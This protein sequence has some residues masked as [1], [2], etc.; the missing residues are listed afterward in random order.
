MI[1]STEKCGRLAKPPWLKVRFPSGEESRRLENLLCANNL[2]SVCVEAHC[3]NRG[4]C[5]ERGTATFLIMGDICT[6]N[7]RFCAVRTGSPL[8]LDENEPHRLV[9][10]A[11]SMGLRHVVITSVTRDD[12]EDGG[13][14]FYS[15]VIRLLHESNSQFTIEVLVPDFQGDKESLKTVLADHPHVLAH[16]L[17]TVPRLYEQVRPQASY[18]R[19][20]QLLEEAKK[21]SDQV[22]IKSGIMVGLGETGEEVEEVMLDLCEIGCDIVTIGQFLQPSKAHLPVARYWE[23]SEFAHLK[24]KGM[25]MGFK[26][27]EAG[28]LVRSSYYAENA[29]RHVTR[30]N[31]DE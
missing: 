26:H 25:A 24:I 28:P 8:V 23:P 22:L 5:W 29:L 9:A 15:Q 4:E 27:V 31:R 3:P 12:L 30:R 19:S 21:N 18:E 10:T 13:A 20:L 2:H 16:N 17:E 6:R 11:K 14:A 7:C 1:S